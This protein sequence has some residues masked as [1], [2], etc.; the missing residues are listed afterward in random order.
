MR[1]SL[2][3]RE[4][5]VLEFIKTFWKEEG[6]CPST[7]EIANGKCSNRQLMVARKSKNTAWVLVRSLVGKRYLTEHWWNDRTFWRPV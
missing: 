3:H 1:P 2:T 6:R 4:A 5:E 7:Q